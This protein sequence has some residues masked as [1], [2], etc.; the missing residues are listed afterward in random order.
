MTGEIK[1][2]SVPNTDP[3]KGIA[4]ALCR[5]FVTNR[6]GALNVDKP[7]SVRKWDHQAMYNL[8][9]NERSSSGMSSIQQADEIGKVM[10]FVYLTTEGKSW[11]DSLAHPEDFCG[12]YLE[13]ATEWLID[14]SSKPARSSAVGIDP[15]SPANHITA[16][17]A[18][19]TEE[20]DQIH[21]QNTGETGA[22]TPLEVTPE[23]SDP[24]C[25][26]AR[27]STMEEARAAMRAYTKKTPGR[28][29]A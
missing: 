18:H 11:V 22:P 20:W 12:K 6:Q 3:D 29:R 27:A 24:E 14:N 5:K 25:M 17:R 8:L 13:I 21:A 15:V 10:E 23:S 4:F 9:V 16:Q 2:D 1:I 26:L 7:Q 19:T 28:I